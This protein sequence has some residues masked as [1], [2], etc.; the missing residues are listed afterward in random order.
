MESV[1][2][3]SFAFQA[4]MIFNLLESAGVPARIDGSY[5]QGIGGEI[6]LGNAVRVRVEPERAAEARAIIAEWD[7]AAVPSDEEAAAEAEAA[8]L[9]AGKKKG[10]S[11]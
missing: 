10:H 1:Y 7:S 2:E 9:G 11:G 8:G 6:P 5:L 3:T 4:Q